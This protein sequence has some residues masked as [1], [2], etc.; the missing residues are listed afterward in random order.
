[1]I[2]Y[3]FLLDLIFHF[4]SFED[5]SLYNGSHPSRFISLKV[6]YDRCPLVFPILRRGSSLE[7]VFFFSSSHNCLFVLFGLC[8][9]TNRHTPDPS[10]H[11]AF[12]SR[13]EIW[14]CK[15]LR[16]AVFR[17]ENCFHQAQWV[18]RA[19]VYRS[20]HKEYYTVCTLVLFVSQLFACCRWTALSPSCLVVW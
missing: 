19:N 7:F 14:S 1:M 13:H 11:V 2:H 6:K 5:I 20:F 9:W 12:R 10:Q 3:Q 8:K 16:A 18:S 17:R 4:V 15:S